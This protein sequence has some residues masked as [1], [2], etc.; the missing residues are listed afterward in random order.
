MTLR[1]P[2][3]ADRLAGLS[4]A[5][6]GAEARVT[7]L[8]C[9]VQPRCRTGRKVAAAIERGERFDAIAACSDSVAI[10][11]MDALHAGQGHRASATVAV[12]GFDDTA[13]DAA[14]TSVRQDWDLAGRLLAGKMLALLA[15]EAPI[16]E[17]LPVELVVRGSTAA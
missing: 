6:A 11:A 8:A 15:G 10:G 14:L 7:A 9:P 13:R 4:M 12:A 3:V 2:E 17:M 5:I 16:S 1:I